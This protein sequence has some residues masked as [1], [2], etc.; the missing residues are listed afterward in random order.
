MYIFIFFLTI[1][2][3]IQIS[4]VLE[5]KVVSH[6]QAHLRYFPGYVCH[7]QA[8]L[9][10]ENLV[11]YKKHLGSV[12]HDDAIEMQKKNNQESLSKLLNSVENYLLSNPAECEELESPELEESLNLEEEKEEAEEYSDDKE[13]IS[14]VVEELA[15]FMTGDLFSQSSEPATREYYH[16]DSKSFILG[17]EL[18]RIETDPVE[19]E[20]TTVEDKKNE[21]LEMNKRKF[22][23]IIIEDDN[24]EKEKKKAKHEEDFDPTIP[25][26]WY[27][28]VSKIIEARGKLFYCKDSS[29]LSSKPYGS[30]SI[31][32]HIERHHF[33]KVT[34]FTCG[35]CGVECDTLTN[36][37]AHMRL[38]H[39]INNLVTM[40]KDFESVED[41]KCFEIIQK[42]LIY[43]SDAEKIIN[44]E[45][46]MKGRISVR[47]PGFGCSE[48]SF[49]SR[50]V[51]LGG[52]T[53]ILE[54]VDKSHLQLAG[55]RCSECSLITESVINFT[56]HLG[57][58]HKLQLHLL[59]NPALFP[60]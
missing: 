7:C 22:E 3:L 43:P 48:C 5:A 11:K 32:N 23:E 13:D 56:H 44:W 59:Q 17:D 25:F 41:S 29:C 54:H 19:K 26:D 10:C 12:E 8:G 20:I 16:E 33:K 30:Q 9:V 6:A 36:Y 21:R 53:E 14:K 31:L 35:E 58:H 45:Q 2:F 52:K 28:A 38:Q 39:N 15:N 47:Q 24:N 57:S 37:Q 1:S 34:S 4:D 50:P 55:Y 42:S 46:E 18:P 51:G 27:L 40:E 49:I 60:L